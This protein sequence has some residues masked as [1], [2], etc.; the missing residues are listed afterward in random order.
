[1]HRDFPFYGNIARDNRIE[2]LIARQY[3]VLECRPS[4]L[5]W[6]RIAKLKMLISPARVTALEAVRGL[7]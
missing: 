4:S 2:R 5:G 3:R 6:K 1:M 7:L